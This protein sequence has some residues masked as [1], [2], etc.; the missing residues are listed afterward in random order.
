[1]NLFSPLRRYAREDFDKLKSRYTRRGKQKSTH[2]ETNESVHSSFRRYSL[3]FPFI[4]LPSLLILSSSLAPTD[5]NEFLH[6]Y[7]ISCRYLSLKNG[8]TRG[9]SWRR[10]RRIWKETEWSAVQTC[11]RLKKKKEEKEKRYKNI[12]LH[13]SIIRLKIG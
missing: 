9:G 6:G 11:L 4:F 2:L 12:Q 10:F 13:L 3:L 5:K 1:M 7:W 8:V